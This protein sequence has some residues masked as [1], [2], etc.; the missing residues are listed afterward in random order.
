[1]PKK[2]EAIRPIQLNNVYVY[3]THQ[4]SIV[5]SSYYTY[6]VKCKTKHSVNFLII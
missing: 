1:M 3:T 6:N 4:T 2:L 5:V